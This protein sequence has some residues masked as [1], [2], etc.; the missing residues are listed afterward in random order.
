MSADPQYVTHDADI[1]P[2][3]ALIADPTRA[4]ILTVLLD[5][6]PLAAGEL[7]RLAG[8]SA[9]TASA[10]LARL[11]GGDLVR[12]ARQGRHRYYRLAGPEIAAV[13][14]ALAH[15][16]P[17]PRPR[18]LRQSRQ[19]AALQDARTSYDHLAGRARVE[20]FAA[21]LSTK[22]IKKIHNGCA[23]AASISAGGPAS[24][25]GDPPEPPALG[26]SPPGQYSLNGGAGTAA[27]AAGG[28]P[29]GGYE[30]TSAWVGTRD[31]VR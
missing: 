24:P 23:D 8:V 15:V 25:R 10:H 2:V 28:G 5:G 20:L 12:V 19:A 16:S 17:R 14:E 3:A 21:L 31:G 13:I 6:R 29:G 9:A 22:V 11:L 27:S 26:W 1:A 7:A 4:A 18:S 30:R